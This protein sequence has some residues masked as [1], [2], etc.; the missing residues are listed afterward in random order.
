[1]KGG[2]IFRDTATEDDLRQA[3]GI[4]SKSLQGTYLVNVVYRSP[5]RILAIQEADQYNLPKVLDEYGNLHAVLV[6]LPETTGEA[7]V[8]YIPDIPKNIFRF[9]GGTGVSLV[10]RV[11]QELATNAGPAGFKRLV[12]PQGVSTRTQSKQIAVAQS[13]TKDLPE[14]VQQRIAAMAGLTATPRGQR[15]LTTEASTAI[16]AVPLPDVQSALARVAPPEIK[17]DAIIDAAVAWVKAWNVEH[18]APKGQVA[19]AKKARVAAGKELDALEGGSVKPS[20]P[21]PAGSSSS[22]SSSAA[23][24]GGRRRT[25]RRRR[26]TRR[27]YS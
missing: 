10:E 14:V 9:K 1:M 16:E 25:R 13:A 20:V 17:A 11:K 8:E 15:P 5:R 2:A 4:L 19:A 27:T 21:M 7:T 18:T 23:P 3:L 22:S 26:I 24:G 12:D 6:T